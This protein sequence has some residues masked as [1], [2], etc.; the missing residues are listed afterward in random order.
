MDVE[1][2]MIEL[3]RVRRFRGWISSPIR[4]SPDTNYLWKVLYF[5]MTLKVLV[6]STG[7]C[8][9]YL[10]IEPVEVFIARERS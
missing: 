6:N 9:A 5:R 7:A 8:E 3:L 2:S 10:T 1:L 4:Q